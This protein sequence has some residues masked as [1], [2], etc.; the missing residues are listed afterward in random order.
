MLQKRSKRPVTWDDDDSPPVHG[1]DSDYGHPDVQDQYQEPVSSPGCAC[2]CN[3]QRIY[4]RW[5]PS[6]PHYEDDDDDDENAPPI[7]GYSD[8]AGQIA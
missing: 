7:S 2:N 6:K 1:V 8:G 5:R 3:C 4:N